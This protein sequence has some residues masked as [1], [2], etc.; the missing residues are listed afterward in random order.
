MTT[1]EQATSTVLSTLISLENERVP[2]HECMGRCLREDLIADRDFPPFDRVMMDG[3][4]IS[5]KKFAAGQRS[6]LVEKLQAAGAPLLHLRSSENCLEVM[7]GAMRPYGTDAVIRYEDV[8][9]KDGVAT[10]QIEEVKPWQNIHRQATDRAAGSV[11]VAAGRQISAAEIGVAATV[12]KSSL[13][14][15]RMPKVAVISTG[16][17][18]VDVD[19]R[20][21]PH[22]IRRSNSHQLAAAVGQWGVSAEL[23]HLADDPAL[24]RP[25]LADAIKKYDALIL[26][27]GVSMGKLD[28]VPSVLAELG[29]EKGFHKV[30]QRPGKP[31]WFGRPKNKGAVVFAFPGNPVSSFMC[32]NRYFRP[33]LR[34]S[35]GLP[36]FAGGHAILGRDF[37]FKP[38]LTYFL[39]VKISNGKDGTLTGM[40]LEGKGSGDLANLT[41][42]D[43]FLELPRGRDEFMAG[44]VFPLFRYR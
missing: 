23:L 21:L 32:L 17:E 3:I 10:V 24:I 38:D 36:F 42:T 14:V 31:F 19:K 5:Q 16:D 33:W 18:L 37:Y 35:Q 2:L 4:A 15:A 34:G 13:W 29:V 9:L 12:G 25:I 8:E 7:T 39:Q 20:P 43:A 11:I 44:E 41:E 26:S 22:Q 1:V 28:F 6:F 40:P 30:G 27:G